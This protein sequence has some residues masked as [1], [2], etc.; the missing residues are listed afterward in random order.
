M[1]AREGQG[2]EPVLPASDA[3]AQLAKGAFG[4]RTLT[5]FG[6]SFTAAGY[7][8]PWSLGLDQAGWAGMLVAFAIVGLFYFCL[9]QCLAEMS[10]AIPSSG[11]GQ[12]FAD[13]AFGSIAGFAAGAAG[14]VQWI[15]SAAA[16]AVLLGTYVESLVG[17]SA[18]VVA[19]AAYALFVGILLAGAGEAIV[20]TLVSSLLALAGAMLFIWFTARVAG[21]AAFGALDVHSIRSGGVWLALPFGVTFFLGLEGVPLAAEEA[22]D[23]ARDVPRGLHYALAIVALLGSAVLLFGPAGAGLAALRGSSEPILAGL[24]ASGVAAPHAAVAAINIA[25]VA[26]L[27]TSLF[28]SLYACSRLVFAMARMR[29]LPPILSYLNRRRAPVAA[30][31]VPAAISA[32]LA[33]SGALDQLIVVMVFCACVSYVLM[34]ASFI[35]LRWRRPG[36]ARPYR[37]RAGA[38]IALCGI[39][40][41]V[42]IFS[43]C[44]LADPRWSAVGAGMMAMLLGYRLS[45]P[46]AASRL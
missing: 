22:V 30:L 6:A 14:V 19:M 33:V 46:Q 26:G 17:V 39:A 9:L 40:L 8:A 18:T 2:A 44:I 43:S 24:G 41:G 20:L 23:P 31:V 29:E 28:G 7:F 15:C 42:A 35:G 4:W 13:E 45:R 5:L 16:L 1:T 37:V 32:L 11:G 34:F 25:A 10:A 3:P 12:A 38:V 36:L 21:H 27:G